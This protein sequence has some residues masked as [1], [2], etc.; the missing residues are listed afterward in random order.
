[1]FNTLQ[2]A[3]GV[4][5]LLLVL[6]PV[7]RFVVS[8]L[9]SVPGPLWARFSN[10]YYFRAVQ[11][12]SFHLENL[13]LHRQYGAVV[14]VAPNLYSIDD[15]STVKKIYGVGSKWEKSD[16]Y[17][18]WQHPDPNMFNLFSDRNVERHAKTRRNFQGMYAL[19]AL[20]TYEDYVDEC[21]A[22][23]SRRLTEFSDS[24]KVIDLGHWF[25]CYAF[26]VIGDITYSQRFGFLDAGDDI[27][28]LLETLQKAMVYGVLVGVYPSWHPWIFWVMQKISGSGA[29]GRNYLYGF[30]RDQIKKRRL[31]QEKGSNR[32]GFGGDIEN[33]QL[34]DGK[35]GPKDFLSKIMEAREATP[36]KVSEYDVQMVGG[37]NINAGSDTTAV[38]LSAIMFYL[39]RNPR[40]MAKLRKEITELEGNGKVNKD[41]V[42]FQDSLNMTYLQ[43]VI[44]EA[45]RLHS[46]TGLPL[47]RVVP[48]G[49]S[50]L[51]GRFFPAGTVVGINTWVA[52]YNEEVFGKDA[53]DFRPERWI[54]ES[55]GGGQ[56]GKKMDAYYMPVS[57]KRIFHCAGLLLRNGVVW[58]RLKDMLGQAHFLS[59]DV[60]AYTENGEGVRF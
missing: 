52:H 13:T 22:I 32:R 8:P 60:E 48:E 16:W 44:K 34:M 10:L 47:W 43:A 19:S 30:V 39:C 1:M 53:K 27:A 23:F 54:E 50:S 5:L 26:D 55:H 12:G 42:G 33:A 3:L 17:S 31:E 28:G 24:G 37:N 51:C 11:K 35:L 15:P 56:E 18:V 38:S 14:R 41:M 2:S 6:R 59:R 4:V 7:F 21:A 58:S 9:R 45:L 57:P 40:A 25:Q 36:E 29:A 49:G 46:A 20:V